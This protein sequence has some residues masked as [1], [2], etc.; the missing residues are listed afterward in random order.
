MKKSIKLFVALLIFSVFALG[1][2]SSNGGK[3]KDV[4][5]EQNQGTTQNDNNETTTN[6]TDEKEETSQDSKEEQKPQGSI[7]IEE[8]E[9]FS[10]NGLTLTATEYVDDSWGEGVKILVNNE[11]DKKLTVSCYTSI[12]NNYMTDASFYSTVAAG[13]KAN[14]SLT[15]YDES[16]ERSGIDTIGQMELYF[17]VYETETYDTFYESDIIVIKT[18]AYDDMQIKKMDDGQELYNKNGIKIVG[19]ELAEDEYMGT[20]L[21]LFIENN[22]GDNIVV[23][24]ENVSV[25]GYMVSSFMYGD[26]SAGKMSVE[27]LTFYESDLEENDIT[28]IEEIEF[29]FRIY[30]AKTYDDIDETDPITLTIK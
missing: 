13:K 15:F 5:N 2:G 7:T 12:V 24:T 20:S 28:S 18:S 30:N 3:I 10:Y 11:T 27:S 9:L 17:E 6:V 19:R 22:T 4:V 21:V 26:V 23:S 14:E 25:N 1:S 16:L 29:E 8:Q